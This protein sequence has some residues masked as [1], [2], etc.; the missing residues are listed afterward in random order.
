MLTELDRR[1][2]SALSQMAR[3]ERRPPRRLGLRGEPFWA[4]ILAAGEHELASSVFQPGDPED[5]VKRLLPSIP[6]E[7]PADLTLYL[8]LEP[9]AGFDRLPPVTESVRR[10]GVKRVVLGT[11]DPAHRFRG[12]GKRT[13]EGFGIEVVLADGEEAR[14][15]QN[16]VDD[17][18]KC[19]VRGLAFLTARVKI[20]ALE[21]GEFGL[22]LSSEPAGEGFLTDA[23]IRRTGRQADARGGWTVVLDA[24]G[25]E[26]PTEKTILYQPE[27]RAVAG[28]RK[29][30]FENG[31]PNMPA[32]L[33]DLASLGIYSA[34]LSN[35]PELLQRALSDGLVDSVIAEFPEGD[36]PAQAAARVTRVRLAAGAAPIDLRLAGARLMEGQKRSLEARV[37]LQ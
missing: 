8:T 15:C 24:E 10:L 14:E 22:S 17:Y 23:V 11:L 5:A 27:D 16:L 2:L 35:D 12:E 36:D 20:S 7:V 30:S 6:S 26:R 29:L 31:E 1:Y 13:L 9:K 19:M 25:W 37:E 33:R 21:S 3:G 28:A 34:E 18:A 32:L 4:A